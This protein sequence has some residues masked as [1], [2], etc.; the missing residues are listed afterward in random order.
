MATTNGEATARQNYLVERDEIEAGKPNIGAQPMLAID[1]NTDGNGYANLQRFNEHQPDGFTSIYGAAL[2]GDEGQISGNH[3]PHYFMLRQRFERLCGP[4]FKVEVLPDGRIMRQYKLPEFG[5][6]IDRKPFSAFFGL[7]DDAIEL[8]YGKQQQLSIES[9]RGGAVGGNITEHYNRVRRARDMPDLEVAQNAKFRVVGEDVSGPVTIGVFE[10]FKYIGQAKIDLN[11]FSGYEAANAHFRL[12]A[13]A[14]TGDVTL[15][16]TAA[17]GNP[18][19]ITYARGTSGANFKTA[20]Q[21]LLGIVSCNVSGSVGLATAELKTIKTNSAYTG[22]QI[23]IGTGNSQT[24]SFAA[25]A[26]LA[27]IKTALATA[28]S[29]TG[30]ELNLTGTSTANA[31]SKGSNIATGAMVA[32]GN[33]S[34]L[35]GVSTLFDGDVSQD[36]EVAGN[37]DEARIDLDLL[38]VRTLHSVDMSFASGTS[39]AWNIYSKATA[40]SGGS[41][42]AG[43]GTL[44]GTIQATGSTATIAALFN[45]GLSTR[46]LRFQAAGNANGP[47]ATQIRIYQAVVVP[48]A[49]DLVLA[50][51]GSNVVGTN[52][53]DFTT[54]TLGIAL[55]TTQQGSPQSNGVIDIVITSPANTRFSIQK[56]AGDSGW[57]LDVVEGGG[58]GTSPVKPAFEDIP[59]VEQVTITDINSYSKRNGEATL[60]S[61]PI[62]AGCVLACLLNEGS[63]NAIN[64]ASPYN[65]NGTKTAGTPA[66]WVEEDYGNAIDFGANSDGGINFGNSSIFNFKSQM[67]IFVRMKTQN[68]SDNEQVIISKSSSQYGSSW[69]FGLSEDGALYFAMS[70]GAGE[71]TE[72]VYTSSDYYL[73]DEK[74]YDLGMTYDGTKIRLYINGLKVLDQEANPIIYQNQN[75]NVVF[76]NYWNG[77]GSDFIG[78]VDTVRLWGRKISDDF[79]EQLS[80]NAYTGFLVDGEL[81]NNQINKGFEIEFTGNSAERFYEIEVF[82][83]KGYFIE[84]LSFGHDG[85]SGLPYIPG[86]YLEPDHVLRYKADSWSDLQSIKMGVTLDEGAAGPDPEDS[87]IIETSQAGSISFESMVNPSYHEDRKKNPASHVD[88][89]MNITASI[90]L[91]KDKQ[92]RCEE[93]YATDNLD[94][95]CGTKDWFYRQAFKCGE[96]EAWATLHCTRNVQPDFPVDNNISQRQFPLRRVFHPNGSCILT[97]IHPATW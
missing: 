4:A 25:G 89:D 42:G 68:P 38:S 52:Y 22:T 9:S 95:G 49:V 65:N 74:W 93:I 31:V 91:P 34:G 87:H 36:W 73:F 96:W 15:S 79:M 90:T 60:S 41:T 8:L 45:G 35:A 32:G 16:V 24:A 14:V 20:L 11:D 40:F 12:I 67:S 29:I 77:T 6:R 81:V 97:S 23:S 58:D 10:N 51:N 75:N 39:T 53:P 27:D 56:T 85:E 55:A 21:D 66:L 37:N 59:G 78:Q 54:S 76:G 47:R 44:V 2:V 70:T 72:L 18:E 84:Q 33:G 80:I 48:G 62:N 69:R 19:T 26:T 92:G 88:G 30:T 3:M 46:Y 94:G 1:I 43:G 86:S 28:L 7:E 61:H 57:N 13:S 83:G 17:G 64:D 63:G 50:F 5:K 82:D 71:E